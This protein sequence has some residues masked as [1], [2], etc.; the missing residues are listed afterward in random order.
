V[1]GF[2]Q[3]Q[4]AASFVGAAFFVSSVLIFD[5]E[6]RLDSKLKHT[7]DK[8]A[9]VVAEDFAKRFIGLRHFAFATDASAEL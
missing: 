5:S 8:A 4:K 2:A 1:S 3:E 7:L 6:L 9:Q